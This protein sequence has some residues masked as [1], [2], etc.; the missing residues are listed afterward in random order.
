M[1]LKKLNLVHFKN[2]READLTLSKRVNCFTGDNGAGKTN[3]LDAIYYLAFT[4]SYF[5]PIDS[6]NIAHE[7]GFFV[8][9][10]SFELKGKKHNIYCGMKR[11]DK[12]VF[13]RNKKKYDKFSDHIGLLPL[14]FVSPADEE[15]IYGGS[16]I[17][18]KFLD[19][20]ISQF[21]KSY[22][23]HLIQ[24]Q[25]ALL[26]RNKLLKTFA[27]NRHFDQD[28][29]EVWDMQLVQHGTPVHEARKSFTGDF[30]H[31]F[32]KYYELLGSDREKAQVTYKSK[33][34]DNTF[35][36]LLDAAQNDDARKLYTTV[37]IH[38]DDLSFTLNGYSLKKTG[39]QGQKKSFL[40]ALKLAQ[41]EFIKNKKDTSPI[42]LLD[43]IFDKLDKTRVKAL[44]KIVSKEDFGQV[45]VTDTSALRV[46]EMFDNFE[47]EIRLFDV[48]P[49]EI[50][51]TR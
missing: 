17:R 8:I 50:L 5:N 46:I 48:T 43:D 2:H 44:M 33:L 18:R 16:E 15:L 22:L 26:Q 3:I 47:T 49:D 45:F 28:A 7:E 14:V 51:L 42:L 39:S 41:F 4:K 34:N 1:H 13:K 9:E 38:K 29:L 35:Q 32:Q 23:E 37:G 11:G 20:V 30:I 40:T 36:D 24:Y 19:G 10:G 31:V 27:E 25:K 6:Q 21:N 12:K